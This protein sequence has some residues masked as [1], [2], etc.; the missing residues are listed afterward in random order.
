MNDELL[1]A[2]PLIVHRSSFIVKHP[3]APFV[4]AMDRE[5]VVT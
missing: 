4:A 1:I 2:T 5:N 3:A